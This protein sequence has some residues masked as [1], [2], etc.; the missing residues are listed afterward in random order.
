MEGKSLSDFKRIV[1]STPEQV[2]A[3]VKQDKWFETSRTKPDKDKP[4]RYIKYELNSDGDEITSISRVTSETEGT[5]VNI[6]FRPELIDLNT[7]LSED[8]LIA[9]L[10]SYNGN[11]KP[12]L[13]VKKF[14][15][16]GGQATTDLEKKFLAHV[17]WFRANGGLVDSKGEENKYVTEDELVKA[18]RLKQPSFDAPDPSTGLEIFNSEEFKTFTDVVNSTSNVTILKN[19]G[20][21]LDRATAF[22]SAVAGLTTGGRKKSRKT[23]KKS[24]KTYQKSRKSRK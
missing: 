16:N 22:L 12:L 5:L 24:R 1:E 3:V 11:K 4:L 13:E 6:N 2:L 20:M 7:P 19:L 10:F 9:I 21:D 8:D 14:V 17:A 23:H 15:E 18:E